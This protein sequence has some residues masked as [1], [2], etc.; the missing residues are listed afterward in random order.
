MA[1]SSSIEES[2]HIE[3]TLTEAAHKTSHHV[4]KLLAHKELHH[5]MEHINIRALMLLLTEFS[6]PSFGLCEL[7]GEQSDLAAGFLNSKLQVP[8]YFSPFALN[9]LPL[10]LA[11]LIFQIEL[12]CDEGYDVLH[13]RQGLKGP[14]KYLVKPVRT[15]DILEHDCLNRLCN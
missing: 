15:E 7:G 10:E 2:G 11:T 6:F 3:E 1:N 12:C 9:S 13:G 5:Q 8:A 4:Q 14:L